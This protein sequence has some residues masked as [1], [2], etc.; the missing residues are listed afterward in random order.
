MKGHAIFLRKECLLPSGLGLIQKQFCES[1]MS[2]EDTTAAALD[3]KVRRTGWH[4]MWFMEAYSCL[5]FGRTAE[6]ARGRAITLAFVESEA[7][8]QRCRT[9]TGQVHEIPRIPGRQ[10]HPSHT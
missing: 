2:V 4:F 6:S 10:G 9:R 7:E 8:F 3:T 1:W 5:G